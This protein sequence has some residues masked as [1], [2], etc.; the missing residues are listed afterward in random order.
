MNEGGQRSS[1]CGGRESLL[2]KVKVGSCQSLALGGKNAAAP[3]YS[4]DSASGALDTQARRKES[5]A[6]RERECNRRFVRRRA[7]T[8]CAFQ[9]RTTW[10]SRSFSHSDDSPLKVLVRHRLFC[11][12]SSRWLVGA[13]ATEPVHQSSP[14]PLV[15]HQPKLRRGMD[16]LQLKWQI[17]QE[18]SKITAA[19]E[20]LVRIAQA[21][22]EQTAMAAAAEN[23]RRYANAGSSS[24]FSTWGTFGKRGSHVAETLLQLRCL[25]LIFCGPC[26]SRW[27]LA[28]CVSVSRSCSVC[29]RAHRRKLWALA[30][31]WF[32]CGGGLLESHVCVELLLMCRACG[33]FLTRFLA[34]LL[35]H[36]VH[37]H[38]AMASAA[39]TDSAAAAASSPP[40]APV[41]ELA[42]LS[43]TDAP[44]ATESALSAD[45]KAV[46]GDQAAAAPSSPAPSSAAGAE[47]DDAKEAPSVG[48]TESDEEEREIL[49]LKGKKVPLKPG[50]SHLH[51]MRYVKTH[52]RRP[53]KP[54]TLA[55]VSTHIDPTRSVWMALR[56]LVY[57]V[58]PYLRYHPGGKETLMR[59]AGKDATKMFGQHGAKKRRRACAAG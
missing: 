28:S 18:V 29:W 14:K 34:F 6:E 15:H 50:F 10:V 3:L 13:I 53:L 8:G 51:W 47:Y 46:S 26:W 43:L 22:A 7:A 52:V 2:V 37:T 44:S 12:W 45:A 38:F 39:P 40:P 33:C 20:E 32:E 25:C 55:Q 35:L 17:G 4:A 58:T 57:D 59:G 41:E 5:I 23:K 19:E 24:D 16:L 49:L 9:S 1:S 56:G 30:G 54:Y 36:P 27:L 21:A 11:A 48:G 42:S 31:E